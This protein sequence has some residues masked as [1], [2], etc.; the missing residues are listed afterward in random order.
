MK[1]KAI[2][3]IK[4]DKSLTPNFTKDMEHAIKTSELYLFKRIRDAKAFF[5]Q[6]VTDMEKMLFCIP[7]KKIEDEVEDF[8]MVTY[9]YS[10]GKTEYT[11]EI[12]FKKGD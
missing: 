12:S 4:T 7:F 1:V 10:S 6:K 11:K 8:H 3:C 2:V 5:N 9:T